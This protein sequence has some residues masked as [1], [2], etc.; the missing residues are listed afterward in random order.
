MLRTARAHLAA[1][2]S[3]VVLAL[4]PSL[5]SAQKAL[6]YCPIGID[7]TGC[8]TV[9]SALAGDAIRFPGGADAGYDGTQGTVDLAG[10]DL[11]GYAVFV[12]P[13]LADGPALQ[14]YA[15]LRNATIAG[16]L[17][18][19]FMGRTAVWSGTPDVGSTNRAAKNELIRNLAAW[20]LADSAATHGPGLVALQDNSDNPAARYG[21]LGAISALSV[22]SD[23]T[24]EVYSNVQVLTATGRAILTNSVGLQIGYTNMG[25]F[26]L[27]RGTDAS[28]ASDEA[29]GGRTS[30]V[31]L[32]TAAGDP[33]DPN[34]ATVRTDKE[35][36]QPGD[37]VTVTGGGWEPGETVTLLFHEEVDPPIH[38]D[39]SLSAVADP[40][41]HI[42]SREYEI[43]ETDLGVRFTITATGTTS[44]RTAQATFTDDRAITGATVNGVSSVTVVPGATITAAVTVNTTTTSGGG[45]NWFSTFWLFATSAP[46]SSSATPCADTPDHAVAGTFTESFATTAPTTPGTYNAYFIAYRTAD[47]KNNPSNLFVLPNAVVVQANQ[48]PVLAA[49]GNKSVDELAALAFTATATDPNAGQTLAFSLDVGAAAGAAITA[50]G[51]FT[52]TPTEAQGPGDYPVTIR[53]SDNGAPA[54]SDF[55]TIT[56]HVNEVNVAP[57]LGTIGSR[58]VDELAELAFTATATDADLPANSLTF[59]LVGAPTGASINA[60]SGGFSWTPTEAQGPD[61]Y[62]FTVKVTDSGSGGL[63]DEESITVHVNEVNAAAVLTGVPPSLAT[64]ELVAVTFDADATDGDTP[65]QPL[66]F[67][68]AGAPSGASI[69]AGTGAFSWTPTEA[70]GPGSYPFHV[71]VSDGVTAAQAAI[72]ITVNEINLAPVLAAIGN[73][74]ADELAALTFTASATDADLPANTLSFSLVGAPVGAAIDAATGV[75]TWTPTE[76]QG[77]SD[78]TFTVKVTDNGSPALSDEESITV[79]VNEVNQAP[80]VAAIPDRTVDELQA[81]EFTAS[82]ADPDLPA[83]AFAFSL[84]GAPAGATINATTGAFTWTPAEADGPGVYTFQVRATDDGSPAAFGETTVKITVIEVNVAPVLAAIGNKSVDEETPLTFSASATDPDLPANTLT[85]SLVGAPAG[86]GINGS[87]GGFSWTP[88]EAQGPSD[89]AFTVRV[90]DSGSPALSDEETITIHVNEVNKAPVVAAIPD[91][92][93]D[94]LADLAF[95]ASAADPDLPANDVSYSLAAGPGPVPAG[96]GINA[97]TGAFTWTPTEAQ[98]PGTYTFKV[99]ATDDGSPAL[100]GETLVKITVNEVNVAPALAAIGNRTVSEETPLSFTAGATDADLP[101]NGLTFSLV[102]APMGASIDGSSGAFTWTPSE[103][104][105]PGSYTFTVKVTDDGTPALSDQEEITV[106][107]NEVNVAPELAVIG[108]Q[109]VDEETSLRFTASATDHDLPPN[110]LTFSLDAGAP[111]GTSIDAATGAFSWTPTEAQGPGSYPVTIR[112]SDNGTPSLDDFETFT[113]TVNEVNQPPVLATI[114]SRSVNEETALAFTATAADPDLPPNALGFSLVGAPAGASINPSTGAFTWTPT[115]AQGPGSYTFVV[116]VTDDGTAALSDDETI[117]VTVN[118]VNRAPVVAA[119][120]PQTV[121][122]ASTVTFI[123]SATDPDLPPNT[124]AFSLVG[125]PAGATIDPATGAFSWTPTDDNPSGTPSD[126]YTFKVRATDNG[127]P[128]LFGESTVT[129]TVN[130]VAPILAALTGPVA[131]NAVGRP[132]GVSAAFT[133]MGTRDTHT[134]LVDWGDGTT[135]AVISES[136]GAGTATGSHAY[137]A[138]GVYTVRMTVTDDDGGASNQSVFQYV[139][140]YDPDAGFVTGGG[141]IDSPLGAYR[142]NPGLTGKANFGFVAKYQK[143]KSVPDGNTEFQFKAGDLNFKST[144]YE[145]LVISGPK[146]Q[147]KGYGTING[148]GN[149]RF[150]LTIEDGD[151]KGTGVDKFRIRIWG[152]GSDLGGS[153]VIYDNQYAQAAL[154]DA[155]TSLGGGSVVIHSDS[156][157]A[158]K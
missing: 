70:Q 105:G 47:C 33:S 54:M 2:V 3:A 16:R 137:T 101:P 84:V 27:V 158:S 73:Q 21:W 69:D 51:A 31:V 43:E 26:G 155:S 57:I 124:L 35:D 10:V 114:G 49:I 112:V 150:V 113:I 118:E 52:W 102:G 5:L 45:Q 119:I 37:T 96:A 136:N 146:G 55:E 79:H 68:L 134:A 138:A 7:A 121:N 61:D 90:T 135:S 125:A 94:E 98:G 78:Q 128:V 100:S 53:V 14:P 132:V 66:T 46:G 116:M 154:D 50:G 36:Y 122:E 72:T 149:Y 151:L 103:A 85:Y 41:G 71:A 32:V 139:V 6:V 24:F 147:Y 58:T 152:D 4:T 40:M 106:T 25:S 88:T 111:A 143:G 18:A 1:L 95:T 60:S 23:T 145:W 39:K 42:L 86:A 81:I 108:S 67:S 44:G 15:M 99:M 62:T 83:D 8:N 80:V 142:P 65:P 48:P 120:A 38:P 34:I 75:F 141:W 97:T 9:V 109:T 107:V 63:S 22:T 93:V 82:A 11:S 123:A 30:R 77:P 28:G 157:T 130:N 115:E 148:A 87:T 13:S 127:S 12:V 129:I 91:Q 131:P 64:N 56:I 74:T 156:K 20:A 89:Y 110:A 29:T 153:G 59:S 76:A 104:Q 140:I 133:D 19:A 117:T 144:G 126:L 17:R 92:H